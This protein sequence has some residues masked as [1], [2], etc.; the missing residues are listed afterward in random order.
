MR[1]FVVPWS[2]VWLGCVVGRGRSGWRGC[3]AGGLRLRIGQSA[4]CLTA[5]RDSVT[6]KSR[7]ALSNHLRLPL[8]QPN[9]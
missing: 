3:S 7:I 2:G 8:I 9:T 4:E 6:A 1:S 5:C